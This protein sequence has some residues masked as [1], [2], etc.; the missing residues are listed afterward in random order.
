MSLGN[1]SNNIFNLIKKRKKIKIISRCI[2]LK[3]FKNILKSTYINRLRYNINV[4]II[5]TYYLLNI[6]GEKLSF[7]I[8]FSQNPLLGFSF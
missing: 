3:K 5:I 2:I 1:D 7:F 4:Y 8:I 6:H